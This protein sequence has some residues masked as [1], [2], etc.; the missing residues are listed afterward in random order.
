MHVHLL[1]PGLLWPAKALHDTA[2]DLDL[3]AFSRLLGRA[4]LSW[5][6]PQGSEDWLCTH[7]GISG[8]APVAALRLLGEGVDPG[9]QIWL[10]ADPEHL[11]FEQGRLL[12]ANAPPEVD[13]GELQALLQEVAPLLQR[14][15]PDFRELRAGAAGSGHAYLRLAAL[16]ALR[17]MAPS[18]ARSGNAHF[19][20]PTGPD[21]AA[22]IRLGN[23]LQMLLH[24]LAQNRQREASGQATL[25]TL[26][27]WGAGALPPPPP[28]SRPAPHDAVYGQG[29]LIAG[30]A[31]WARRAAPP[32]PQRAAQL[33]G[34]G[35]HLVCVDELAAP[36]R[37][38][39]ANAWRQ[40]LLRLERDWF[41]PLA[42]ALFSGRLQSLR[43]TALGREASVDVQLGRSAVLKFWR[44]PCPITRLVAPAEGPEKAAP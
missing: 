17:L 27:F 4:R 20:L 32:L 44:R 36:A 7:F 26:W 38:L 37:E 5:G 25:N 30:L 19:A 39:D 14:E 22:W 10:C 15:L 35:R 11:G 24:N 42:A 34:G 18:L 40:A 12:L 29:P 13:A 31:R 41:A 1:C 33:E 21:A 16:P 6:A 43:I 23:A 28:A 8:A 9:Q 2:F 3:P